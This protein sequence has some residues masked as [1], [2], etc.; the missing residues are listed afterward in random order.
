MGPLVAILPSW[1]LPREARKKVCGAGQALCEQNVGH[2][3]GERPISTS[4]TRIFYAMANAQRH[5][6]MRATAAASWGTLLPFP[7]AHFFFFVE[8]PAVVLSP[9]GMAS[10]GGAWT[11]RLGRLRLLLGEVGG[12]LGGGGASCSS[13]TISSCPASLARSRALSPCFVTACQLAPR[14]S[15]SWTAAVWPMAE[16]ACRAVVPLTRSMASRLAFRPSRRADMHSVWPLK[17]ARYSGVTPFLS[18]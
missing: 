6:H 13:C 1:D 11:R 10:L 15:S 12:D 4:Y 18:K 2:W 8:E 5:C 9:S 16:A 14:D 3:Q 17:A 7:T